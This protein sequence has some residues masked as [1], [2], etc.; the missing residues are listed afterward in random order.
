MFKRGVLVVVVAVL[1]V[2]AASCSKDDKTESGATSTASNTTAATGTTVNTTGST[3]TTETTSSSSTTS[4]VSIPPV[5]PPV[6]QPAACSL[7]SESALTAVGVPAGTAGTVSDDP[8]GE[9]APSKG[10]SWTTPEIG[11]L[12]FYGKDPLEIMAVA[13]QDNPG[14]VDIPGLGQDAFYSSA[15]V[16]YV[17]TGSQAFEVGGALAQA[18]LQ[19]L[20]QNVLT[21][22]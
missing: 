2:A 18:Q 13:R 22:L 14:G 9:P 6:G 10:C 3:G 5:T 4:Q 8:N 21:N 11:V 1:I 20:A 17:D 16:L 15:G 7:L 19:A 12:L